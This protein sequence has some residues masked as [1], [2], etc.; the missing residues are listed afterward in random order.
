[1]SAAQHLRQMMRDDQGRYAEGTSSRAETELSLDVASVPEPTHTAR[2]FAEAARW[3]G[4]RV[5]SSDEELRQ[6][7][8]TVRSLGFRCV[9][10][11]DG[12]TAVIRIG[13]TDDD[14][15][16]SDVQGTIRRTAV[17][18][19][20]D[21]VQAWT[22]VAPERYTADHQAFAVARAAAEQG[23]T[24]LLAS[25]NQAVVTFSDPDDAR[26]RLQED[27]YREDA[28]QPGLFLRRGKDPFGW[29]AV[30]SAHLRTPDQPVQ[31]VPERMVDVFRSE[32]TVTDEDGWTLRVVGE[33]RVHHDPVS[34]RAGIVF[35]AEV[36]RRSRQQYMVLEAFDSYQDGSQWLVHARSAGSDQFLT[37]TGTRLGEQLIAERYEPPEL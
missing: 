34:G 33:P 23:C 1:M 8:D 15:A 5:S 17:P 25:S 10:V 6:A 32:P 30:A 4:R 36:G 7:V 18:S 13:R 29:P 22:D 3:D 21:R 27:G 24:A 31:A 9:A 14:L 35:V 26:R 12:D 37:G 20:H 2:A 19:L 11:V 16:L 28:E